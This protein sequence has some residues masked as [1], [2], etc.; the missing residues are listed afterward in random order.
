MESAASLPQF[1]DKDSLD[2]GK[3]YIYNA[4][5]IL[6]LISNIF[7]FTTAVLSRSVRR[8][9][10]W[11]ILM[12]GWIPWAIVHEFLFFSGHQTGSEPP[13]ALCL[14]QASLVYA[15]PPCMGILTAGTLT[16]IYLL[17]RA[18]IKQRPPPRGTTAIL[19]VLALL[20]G[21]AIVVQVLVFGIRNPEAISSVHPSY[22]VY[23]N[24]RDRTCFRFSA[25][26]SVLAMSELVIML[27]VVS[28]TLYRNW[29]TLERIRLASGNGTML[30]RFAV[31]SLAPATALAFSIAAE[32]D[33]QTFAFLSIVS[34]Q[35]MPP[36]AAIFFGTQRDII[37]A[38]WHCCR[39]QR[40]SWSK[41]ASTASRHS[42]AIPPSPM[43]T[44]R[45]DSPDP[46]LK[47]PKF[48]RVGGD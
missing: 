47:S 48:P 31:F 4:I 17:I 45:R 21:I 18:G 19:C 46:N 12:G 15:F 34:V 7:V 23:C 27:V 3:I 44:P 39:P 6:G 35:S 20:V 28:I 5:Q 9:T 40:D 25:T 29:G 43:P 26:F 11:Y 10:L 8:S 1:V 22:P 36:L 24:A 33:P 41:Y 30:F 37:Q 42:V 38:A 32:K 13:R 16:Q 2:R 14:L